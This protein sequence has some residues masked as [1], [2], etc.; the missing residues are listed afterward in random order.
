MRAV[1]PDGKRGKGGQSSMRIQRNWHPS[2]RRE[3]RGAPLFFALYDKRQHKKG[4]LHTYHA[5]KPLPGP[6]LAQ[7]PVGVLTE[8][9]RNGNPDNAKD[10]DKPVAKGNA[11]PVFMARC[12][13]TDK[14]PGHEQEGLPSATEI[15]RLLIEQNISKKQ[16]PQ[17]KTTFKNPDIFIEQVSELLTAYLGPISAPL[18]NR[19]ASELGGIENRDDANKFITQLAQEITET[20]ERS[21]FLA[22]AAN[23]VNL[24]K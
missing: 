3:K 15:S 14:Q 23:I 21:H 11:T 5:P 17:S 10:E 13:F 22:R 8:A 7:M 4:Q 20:G 12:S 16:S 1:A 9:Y 2:A 24:L 19:I 6:R 18:S